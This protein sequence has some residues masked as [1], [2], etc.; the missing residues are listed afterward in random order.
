MGMGLSRVHFLLFTLS[1]SLSGSSIPVSKD[2]CRIGWRPPVLM[3]SRRPTIWAD[4]PTRKTFQ[5]VIDFSGASSC[6]YAGYLE[7]AKSKSPYRWG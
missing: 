2:A 3:L 6:Y 7:E 5:S 4:G 1:Y